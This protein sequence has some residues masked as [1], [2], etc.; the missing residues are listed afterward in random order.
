MFQGPVAREPKE[1]QC[2]WSLEGNSDNCELRL[3]QDHRLV[4]AG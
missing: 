3:W 2:G 4:G 1:S